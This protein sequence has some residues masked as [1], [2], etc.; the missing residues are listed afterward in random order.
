MTWWTECA[1]GDW[2][3]A[4]EKQKLFHRFL[5]LKRELLGEGGIANKAVYF[6]SPALVGHYRTRAPYMAPSIEV[7]G[8]NIAAGRIWAQEAKR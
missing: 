6:T 1:R 8:R 2:S 5:R 3:M 7:G 4:I